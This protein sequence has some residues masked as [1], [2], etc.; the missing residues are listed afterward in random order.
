M[1]LRTRKRLR[2]TLFSM[3][4]SCAVISPNLAT[5]PKTRPFTGSTAVGSSSKTTRSQ[6]LI[7]SK[8]DDTAS[9]AG[10][11]DIRF[12]A[13]GEHAET[14]INLVLEELQK[15]P[16]GQEPNIK[17][18]K[19]VRAHGE[20]L[21]TGSAVPRYGQDPQGDADLGEKA[22]GPSQL[23]IGIRPKLPPKGTPEI[24]VSYAWCDDSSEEARQRTEVVDRLCEALGLAGWNILRDKTVSARAT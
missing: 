11:G 18:T 12:R 20:I 6:V 16:I 19:R 5:T 21:I 23:Q 3:R 9:E 8:W 22:D 14:L 24:F 10:A 15:L 17:Q 13:W 1:I 2:D 4:A 7:E